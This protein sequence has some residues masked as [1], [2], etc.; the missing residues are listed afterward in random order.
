MARPDRRRLLRG[1]AVAMAAAGLGLTVGAQPQHLPPG[2][3]AALRVPTLRPRVRRLSNGLLVVVLP[4]TPGAPDAAGNGRAGAGTAAVQVWYQVGGKDDPPGRSGFAHLFEHL[5]FKGTGHLADEAFDRLTEDVGG[6]NNAFTTEDT[7]AYL[8]VVPS[9]HVERL[10]WAEAERMA[11]LQVGESQ[12]RSERAVVAS[13]FRQKVLDDPY[14]R[15]FHAMAPA[16]WQAHPYRHPVIGRVEELNAASLDDVRRFHATFY[17]PDNATLIVA[18]D[19]DPVR[20]DRWVDQHFG[21]LTSPGTPV[22]RVVVREPRRVHDHRVTLRAPRVPAP[23]VALMWQA[24]GAAHADAAALQVAAALLGGGDSARLPVGL[25]DRMPLAQS[26]GFSADL[27]VDG[28]MLSAWAIAAGAPAP[29]ADAGVDA[30]LS[31]LEVALLRGVHRLAHGR[32][33]IGELDKVRTQ[34]LTEALVARQTAEGR[35]LA[36]G[37]A[38]V[39]RQDAQA[40]DVALAQLQAVRAEDVQRVLRGHV[41]EVPRVTLRYVQA[42]RSA[43]GGG[44]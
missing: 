6:H 22:P 11:H 24:P 42:P 25:V 2:T 20:V 27:L 8:N 13:E 36:L 17:R 19:V 28:G 38:V 5:M 32:I 12:L 16:F 26:A 39:Q 3:A 31:A 43:A 9:N 30:R 44:P 7:T 34:L 40:A 23:A 4:D 29:A 18:G 41:L 1:G 21:P 15:L 35:A 10:L 14:G 33:P 37:W